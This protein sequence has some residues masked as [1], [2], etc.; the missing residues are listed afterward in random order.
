VSTNGAEASRSERSSVDL[1]AGLL[2]AASLFFAL[3]ALAYH[4]LTVSAAAIVLGLVSAG[5]SP[6][7]QR[8]AAVALAVAGVC[9]VA[10]MAMAVTLHHSLW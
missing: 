2:G 7:H 3:V 4:P 9:F 10:G 5:M 8:L 1:V 6:H